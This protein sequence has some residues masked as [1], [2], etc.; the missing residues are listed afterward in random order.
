MT[1]SFHCSFCHFCLVYMFIYVFCALEWTDAVLQSM[2]IFFIFILLTPLNRIISLTAASCS[3]F[4][5]VVECERIV[6]K[7]FMTP[8]EVTSFRASKLSDDF[9]QLKAEY[10]RKKTMGQTKD[11]FTRDPTRDLL[12]G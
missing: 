4:K 3:R 6:L 10:E 8:H 2:P 11:D 1:E 7:A 12:A 9:Y 5:D